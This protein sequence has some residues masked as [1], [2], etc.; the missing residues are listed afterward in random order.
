MNKF[1]LLCPSRSRPHLAQQLLQSFLDTQ[2]YKN[3]LLFYI[4]EDDPKLNEYIKMFG[5]E[6]EYPKWAIRMMNEDPNKLRDM[7]NK[8]QSKKYNNDVGIHGGTVSYSTQ[9][10]VIRET[11]KELE[12]KII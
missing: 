1:S 11:L 3:Q 2:K 7:V 9:A 12:G 4:Q 6:P 10:C 8:I 5:E